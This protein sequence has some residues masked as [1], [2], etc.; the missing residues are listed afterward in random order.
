MK[1]KMTCP[2]CGGLGYYARDHFGNLVSYK[3]A[4]LGCFGWGHIEVEE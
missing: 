1:T 4:C 3:V 2:E